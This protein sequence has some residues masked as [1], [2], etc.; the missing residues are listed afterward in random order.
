MYTGS[1]ADICKIAM[2]KLHHYMASHSPSAR[3][4]L[5]VSPCDDALCRLLLQVH[6]ELVYQVLEG[7][8]LMLTSQ[9]KSILESPDLLHGFSDPL[10]VFR[11]IRT[12]YVIVL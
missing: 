6:D 8:V 12:R 4:G 9:L 7:D 2:I 5:L 10:K 11:D 3:Y 1:A